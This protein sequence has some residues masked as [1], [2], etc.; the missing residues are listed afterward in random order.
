MFNCYVLAILFLT[1]ITFEGWAQTTYYS[2]SSSS[3]TTASNWNT[4]RNGSGANAGSFGLNNTWV[5]QN[6]HTMTISTGLAW[7]V[8]IPG[9]TVIIESGGILDVSSILDIRIGVFKIYAGGKYIHRR[10][11]GAVP[12]ATR[13]FANSTNGGNGNGTV[14]VQSQGTASLSN[15]TYG[16]LIINL[17]SDPG[18]AVNNGATL[19]NIEGNFIVSNTRGRDYVLTADETTAHTIG[20]DLQINGASSRLL[21]K[22]GSG[23]L[24]VTV[25]GNLSITSSGTLTSNGQATILFN[26]SNSTFTNNGVLTNTYISYAVNSSKSLTLNNNLSIAASR[27]L[28]VNGTLD[29]GSY[30]VSGSGAF[31]LTSIGTL[32]ISDP[33]GIESSANTGTIRTSTRSFNGGAKYIY[34]G[35]NQVFGSGLPATLTGDLTIESTS[36]ITNDRSRTINSPGNITVNGTLDFN[37]SVLSGTSTFTLAAGGTLKI[38]HRSG[39]NGSIPISGT[40]TLNANATYEFN[41]SAAQVTG[42]LLPSTITGTLKI[43][44]SSGVTLS[45]STTATNVEIAT[46][47][48]DLGANNL[49][50][51][52][53]TITSPSASKMIIAETGE[54]R[55]VFTGNGAFTFPVCDS[56]GTAEYS[57]VTVNMTSGTYSNAYISA[58]VTDD[59]HASNTSAST[60]LTRHWTVNQSG[61][62]NPTYN[63][64]LYYLD[65]DIAGNEADLYGAKYSNNVWTLLN[66]ASQAEN[67][68]SGTGLTSFSDF[69][70][71]ES[72]ALPV[73]LTSFTAK[74]QGTT[75]NLMWETKTEIDNN[76]F[77][78]ERKSGNTWSKIGFVEGHGTTNSPKYYNFTDKNATGN[79]IQYRLKQIDNDGSFE[80]SPIVE[81][82][83]NPTEFTLYQ[84]YPNPFN[85]STMIRFSIPEG[86]TVALNVFN[87][88]GEKVAALLNGQLEAGYH[89]VSF[90]AA[91]LPSGLYFYEIEAGEFRMMKKMVLVK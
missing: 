30:F 35:S 63:I 48:L 81:V 87:T 75:V 11:T 41:G 25:G 79:K 39:L 13:Q 31:V 53:L 34:N 47:N 74:A 82:E 60:Y 1:G 50:V 86:G 89:E 18:A 5:I 78:V 9:G 68:L 37:N 7:D 72:G 8:G 91:N 43:N 65:A 56:T 42:S 45:Q 28:T 4:A 70:G 88:L 71:G 66:A 32:K 85:P 3:A 84:N 6:G 58:K 51:T 52:N 55:K 40:K 21:L 49:T 57:P 62:T 54:L 33:S 20:G 22:N 90:D 26:G 83:L 46:G 17:T 16:N 44:N 15:A 38:S 14:E 76:G 10:G 69:T 61:I 2:K 67:K 36:S 12:G 23:S 24:N 64:D 80:Y 73:E 59:R 29:C 77:E 27:S 19:A